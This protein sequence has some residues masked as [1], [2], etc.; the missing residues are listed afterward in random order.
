VFDDRYRIRDY[1]GVARALNGF[2][3]S[4][5]SIAALDVGCGTGHWLQQLASNGR[6][7]V[8][9]DPSAQMLRQAAQK[10]ALELVQ[11]RAEALPFR[12]SLFDRVFCINSLHHFSDRGQFVSEAARVLRPGG[13]FIAVNLDPHT[14]LDRWWLYDYFENT[15]ELDKERFPSGEAIRELLMHNG[16]VDCRT[17]IARHIPML[18]SARSCLERETARTSTSQ[19]AILTDAEYRR[20]LERIER[21]I[22]DAEKQGRELMFVS[23]LRLFATS[24]RLR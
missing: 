9:L 18:A 24:A 20:G 19:L 3:A 2:L 12:S 7:L 4:D 15:L 6:R 11:A 16:F 17:E 1:T 10:G 13:R 8:G 22:Q 14:G 5:S 21:A 23:D